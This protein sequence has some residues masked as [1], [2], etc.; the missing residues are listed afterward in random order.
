MKRVILFLFCWSLW[1]CTAHGQ[2]VNKT[3]FTLKSNN[4]EGQ[5]TTQEVFTTCGGVNKSPQLSWENPPK[6]TKSFAIVMYDPDA[7]TGSGWWHWLVVN[8]PAGTTELPVD[9]GN[10]AAKL[11]PK[12]AIQTKT[13]YGQVGYGGPC[14]PKG[15]GLHQYMIT[16]HALKTDRLDIQ[17]DAIPATVGYQI[18]ANTIG[19]AS[20]VFYHQR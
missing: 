11:L 9:A 10:P 16:V 4:L 19:K 18:N 12:G 15:H 20:L 13:D 6:G 5:A 7:P 17:S 8:L 14:P 3:T 1:G 2:Q